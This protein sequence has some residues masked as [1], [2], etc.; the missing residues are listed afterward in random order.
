MNNV[1][2]YISENGYFIASDYNIRNLIDP[3]ESELST[4]PTASESNVK[5]AGRD[6]DVVLS[7]TY[8]PILF[9]IVCFTHNS[10]VINNSYKSLLNIFFSIINFKLFE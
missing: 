5:I 9:N 10:L 4:M 7:T 2:C 6:G 1:D 3:S 8:D